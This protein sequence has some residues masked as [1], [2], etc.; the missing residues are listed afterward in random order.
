[1]ALINDADYKQ[2]L[3]MA[4]SGINVAVLCGMGDSTVSG[5]ATI[6]LLQAAIRALTPLAGTSPDALEEA[7]RALRFAVTAGAIPETHG[8]STVA[9]LRALITANIPDVPST[10]T[11]FLT[12]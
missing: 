12:A 5:N 2:N 1:M 6:T 10:Y 3:T 9:A 7:A 4:L 11:G 8:V